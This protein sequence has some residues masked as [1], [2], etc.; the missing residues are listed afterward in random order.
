MKKMYKIVLWPYEAKT[1]KIRGMSKYTGKIVG[2]SRTIS[3]ARK[4][5]MQE[6]K[7]TDK[8]YAVIYNTE[9][10]TNGSIGGKVGEVYGWGGLTANRFFMWYP[11]KAG[12]Y[13]KYKLNKGGSLGKGMQ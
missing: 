3:G 2:E 10:N 8:K 1:E 13:R 12:S 7:N 4:R 9:T 6:L 11:E 5:A